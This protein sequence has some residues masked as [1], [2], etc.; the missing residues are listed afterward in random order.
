MMPLF[1]RKLLQVLFLLGLTTKAYADWNGFASVGA[2]WFSN[3][4]ADF[5]Y[6]NLS[7]GAG[8]T[9][10][11]DFGLDTNLGI[12]WSGVPA[13]GVRLNGQT[14][15]A[16]DA[17]NR[18]M[19]SLTLAN[20]NLDLS[21]N[22]SVTLGRT[23]NPNFLYSDYRQVHYALPWV[24]PPRE[25]Y[26]ITSIFNY[27]GVQANIE[28]MRSGEFG[29]RLTTGLAQSDTNYSR[30]GGYT[31]DR[32]QATQ[33]GYASLAWRASDWLIKLS[34]EQ[35]N[36]FTNNARIDQAMLAIAQSDSLLAQQMALD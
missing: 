26:G 19:P 3:P 20:L 23:Q 7:S 32:L 29:L 27:D 16:R 24:R 9:H 1:S 4:H 30:D 22:F 33:M 31:V 11:V 28:L 21:S 18:V 12:Q 8:R 15:V 2:V 6:N 13:S 14:V 36:L 25:V 34:Y 5:V 17:A 10:N 35:G